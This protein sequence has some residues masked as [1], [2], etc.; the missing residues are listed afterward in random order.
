MRAIN[1]LILRLERL[2]G[3]DQYCEK[4][5]RNCVRLLYPPPQRPVLKVENLKVEV[6]DI[7]EVGMRIFNYMQ[8]ALGPK[9][10][11]TVIFQC[12]VSFSL[13]GKVVWQFKNELGILSKR[14]P[15]FII[16]QEAEHLLKY[17][18]RNQNKKY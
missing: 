7:S 8:H 10:H 9:I 1:E 3:R 16:E 18:H 13:N 17:F 2:Q 11:G 6:V 4:E 15:L 5:K 14:I 12:G